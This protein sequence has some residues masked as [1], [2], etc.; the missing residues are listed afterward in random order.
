MKSD[1]L[2]GGTRGLFL[3]LYPCNKKKIDADIVH[4]CFLVHDWSELKYLGN[5]IDCSSADNCW[6]P[7]RPRTKASFDKID[8]SRL[9]P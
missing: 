3:I 4:T 2:E 1:D 6:L 5:E 8:I 9:G 7:N